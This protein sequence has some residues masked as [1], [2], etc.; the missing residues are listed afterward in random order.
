MLWLCTRV[1]EHYR[2]VKLEKRLQKNV[3]AAKKAE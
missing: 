2:A 1:W 3:K